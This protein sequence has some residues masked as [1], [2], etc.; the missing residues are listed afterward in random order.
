M[1]DKGPGD[2]DADYL[3]YFCERDDDDRYVR[4]DQVPDTDEMADYL[5]TVVDYLYGKATMDECVFECALQDLGDMLKVKL[6][7]GDLKIRRT[8]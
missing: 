5:K 1:W 4:A 3:D 8:A 2:Y 6:P 7:E